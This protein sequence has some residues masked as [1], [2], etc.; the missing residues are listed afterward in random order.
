MSIKK[1]TRQ[2]ITRLSQGS[3][4]KPMMNKM[5]EI[6]TS[7]DSLNVIAMK[8]NINLGG[9]VEQIELDF[10]NGKNASN[11]IPT[12]MIIEK[13]NSIDVFIESSEGVEAE[14]QV[15][16]ITGGV[17]ENE[18][19][20]IEYNHPINGWTAISSGYSIMNGDTISDVV[21][22]ILA[23]FGINANVNA[24]DVSPTSFKI[25]LVS[26]FELEGSS[27]NGVQIRISG[28][29]TLTYTPTTITFEGAT[30]AIANNIS[31]ELNEEV[32]KTIDELSDLEYETNNFISPVSE[33][34][35]SNNLQ[36][37]YI[38][39][40][41][42]PTIQDYRVNIYVYGLNLNI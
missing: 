1:F 32:I 5:N 20:V 25:E 37:S 21:Q 9:S 14:S 15:I 28:A 39:N 10:I 35:V 26:G 19:P 42:S 12:I 36:H 29:P 40:K 18:E 8:E 6:I 22:G 23:S 3:H 4:G 27:Q 16:E 11:T 13:A 24:T 2:Q 34:F 30:D 41:T 31:L 38:V 7:L 33:S 17:T